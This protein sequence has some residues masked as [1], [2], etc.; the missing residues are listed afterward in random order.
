MFCGLVSA[1]ENHRDI[2]AIAFF[3]G[4]V[5]IDV[6][7]VQNSA[8][9]TQQGQDSGFGFLAQVAA[10]ARLESDIARAAGREA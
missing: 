9:L 1:D 10:W 4:R 7:L 2:P 6:H 5:L 3:E 8:K